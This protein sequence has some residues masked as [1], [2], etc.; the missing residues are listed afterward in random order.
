VL[1][2][3]RT[4]VLGLDGSLDGNYFFGGGAGVDNWIDL[5]MNARLPIPLA[6][7]FRT[8]IGGGFN[9]SFISLDKVG[10][11]AE[12]DLNVGLNLLVSL[13]RTDGLG[14]PFGEVRVVL[15]GA[16]QLVFTAGVTLGGR[17]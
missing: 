10:A 17:R 2:P 7:D 11:A 4:G 14:G 1:F 16:E 12:T 3:L 6:Q 13:D 8:R 5:N 15:G 9:A